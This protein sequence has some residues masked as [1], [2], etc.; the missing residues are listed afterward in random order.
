MPKRV[1]RKAGDR[2][3]VSSMSSMSS[4]LSR[5]S[6]SPS[7]PLSLS[8]DLRRHYPT[9]QPSSPTFAPERSYTPTSPRTPTSPYTPISPRMQTSPRVSSA[10]ERNDLQITIPIAM[11]RP[12][13]TAFSG[14]TKCPHDVDLEKG[15]QLACVDYSYEH[16]TEVPEF[17]LGVAEVRHHGKEDDWCRRSPILP[18]P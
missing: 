13:P 16:S 14:W 6:R 1:K 12:P 5:G 7:P 2:G 17:C 3:S 15:S 4:T 11:P 8:L 18:R 10:S 9:S